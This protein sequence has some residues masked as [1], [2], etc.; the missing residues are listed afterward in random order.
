MWT[1]FQIPKNKRYQTNCTKS[2]IQINPSLEKRHWWITHGQTTQLPKSVFNCEIRVHLCYKCKWKI[3]LFLLH[4]WLIVWGRVVLTQN[5]PFM[6]WSVNQKSCMFENN[7]VL[8]SLQDSRSLTSVSHLWHD[9]TC[10]VSHICIGTQ[11]KTYS[12]IFQ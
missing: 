12:A 10:P 5:I 2:S 8:M 11:D 9:M 4:V 3:I 1:L 7:C 6:T